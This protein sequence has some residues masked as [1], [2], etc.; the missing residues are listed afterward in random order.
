MKAVN[1]DKSQA[2]VT[3]YTFEDCPSAKFTTLKVIVYDFHSES[4]WHL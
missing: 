2:H 1:H 3:I 4:D